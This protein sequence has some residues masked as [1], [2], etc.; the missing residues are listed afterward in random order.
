MAFDLRYT[1]EILLNVIEKHVSD[2]SNDSETIDKIRISG[3]TSGDDRIVTF[4]VTTPNYNQIESN[5][6]VETNDPIDVT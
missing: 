5:S 4:E 3:E 2:Y 6:C 1:N